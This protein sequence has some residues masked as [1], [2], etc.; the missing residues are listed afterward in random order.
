M[1]KLLTLKWSILNR[2]RPAPPGPAT[3]QS[4]LAN[5]IDPNRAASKTGK[6]KPKPKLKPKPTPITVPDVSLTNTEEGDE[7]EV[8]KEGTDETMTDSKEAPVPAFRPAVS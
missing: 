2:S 4:L 6:T 3:P 5:I 8:D 1:G 7:V